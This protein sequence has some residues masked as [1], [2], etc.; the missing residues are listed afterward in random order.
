MTSGG[1]PIAVVGLGAVYPGAGSAAE[2]WANVRA[3]V[4]AITD[5]PPHRWDPA[6]YHDPS[7]YDGPAR[8]DRFYCRR[9]G[10]VDDLATADPARFGIRPAAVPGIEPDQLLALRT[11]AEAIADAGGDERLRDRARVGVVL[12]R[13]GHIGPG[14]ARLDQRVTAFHQVAAILTELLP[15]LPAGRLEQIREAFHTRLGPEAPDASDGV[16]PNP[17]ASRV[18]NRFDLR[19]P[20]Y[21]VDAACASS[22]IAVEHAVRALRSGQC[23]A[24]LAGAVHHS[25]HA[26]LWS[27]FSRL[28]ALSPTGMIRPLDRAADGTLLSEGTGM[29]LLKRLPDALRAGDK[30]YA[31]I[32]GAGSSSDGRAS[33]VLNPQ[34]DGQVLALERAWAD[35]GLDPS[36]PD[37]AGLVEA[38]GTGAPAG[39]AAELAALLR[40]FG[41]RGGPLHV[42]TV[43]SMIGHAMPA[44]GMAGMIK[45]ACALRDAVLP[46]TLHVTEPHQAMSGTRLTPVLSAAGWERPAHGPR[47]AVVNAFGFGGTNAHLVLEEAPEVAKAHLGPLRVR[48]GGGDGERVLR[49]AARTPAELADLLRAPNDE[50]LERCD[51]EPADLPCRLAIVAPDTRRLTLARAVADRGTPWRGRG[52]IWFT[53]RPL[54]A[55]GGRLVFLFPGFEASFAPRVDDVADHFGLGRPDLTGRTDMLGHAADVMAVGRLLAAALAET[56]VRP[57]VVAGHS[58]GEW[59]AMLVSGMYTPDVMETFLGALDP[60]GLRV[61]DLLYGALGCGADRVLEV[62]GTRA[63]VVVSH[64]NCPHQSVVCG[65]PDAV[66]EI[67]RRFGS[68]GVL[69]QELPFRTGFHTPM[70]ASLL[71]QLGTAFQALS[72]H[73]PDIPIWSATTVA[74]FPEDEADVRDLVRRHLLEPVR[75]SELVEELYGAGVR[76][77]VQV[78]PGS[79]SGFVGDRLG[80]REHLAMAVNVPQRSGLAQLRRVAAAL[81]AEGHGAGPAAAPPVVPSGP[82]AVRLDLGVPVVRL[83]GLVAPLTP[84]APARPGE[85]PSLPHTDP[86]TAELDAFLR[87]AV[88]SATDVMDALQNTAR[89]PSPA[90]PQ[91]PAPPAPPLVPAQPRPTELTVRRVFSLDTMPYVRDHCLFRQPVDWPEAS[92]GFPVVPLTTLLETMADA[93]RELFPDLVCVGLEQVRAL[94]WV[95]ADPPTGTEVSARLLET[96]AGGLHR[97]EIVVK[98]HTD[99]I[100]L[101]APRYPSPP[102]PDRTPLTGEA[103]PPVPADR[104][105]AERWMFHGPL[106]QGV[107]EIAALASDGVRGVLTSLPTPGALMDNLGQL[108]GHWIQVHGEKD[109]TVFPTGIDRVTWYGPRPPAGALLPATVRTRGLTSTTLR[110]DGELTGPDGRVWCRVEGWTTHR[111]YTDEETWRMKFTPEVSGTA[112]PQPEGWVLAREHWNNG[113]SRELLMRQYL[114]AAERP[115]YEALTPREQGPWLLGRIAAKDAVRHWLWE[116]G[117]GPLFP[118]EVTI[119]DDASGR[120]RATGAF[121]SSPA[122]SVAQTDE[123]AVALVRPAGR[124]CHIEITRA[125]ARPADPVADHAG[126]AGTG[127]REIEG[128][129]V[130]W[131]LPEPGAGDDRDGNHTKGEN[132]T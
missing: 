117:H 128:H 97:V 28:R 39:D 22:L 57:D 29:A 125:D 65:D 53:P 45:A 72:I 12:G 61:P 16:V 37:A 31:V 60:G 35:A 89:T 26:T 112:E 59:T 54:L 8:A 116:H 41:E 67:L 70:A 7:A 2:L 119:N 52:D 33:G 111:F 10:F 46:P 40:V 90:V 74:P 127:S 86:V 131:T 48:S 62:L 123:L 38:H 82:G 50:L 94:R 71:E 3:G 88:D 121:G 23:D 42:G 83:D 124:T 58:L 96:G 69:G 101:L 132:S 51:Q 126:S 49:L 9:G 27:V 55:S 32:R 24:M 100:V 17:V 84:P 81:W 14:L 91:A 113:S 105:Y 76:A 95:T 79:I 73:P 25:H 34:V 77:F 68:E 99:G 15:D 43:K 78:G 80:D 110:S 109:Q 118:A 85:W 104:F 114:N 92:D 13:G 93:A 129:V 30:I 44:A 130:T 1:E 66:R 4:D 6:L 102:E 21:T 115:G 120:P 107:R 106:Y 98:G 75:F 64:D 56:G 11:A 5:V 36:A 87:E 108:A 47:R 103:P 20:A 63:D 18:A 122:L 19:G